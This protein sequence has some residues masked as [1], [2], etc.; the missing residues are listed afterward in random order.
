MLQIIEKADFINKKIIGQ[1]D[2]ELVIIVSPKS[3][4]TTLQ[5][6]KYFLTA[7]VEV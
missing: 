6:Q 5:A 7:S 4:V 3:M 1:W 2:I